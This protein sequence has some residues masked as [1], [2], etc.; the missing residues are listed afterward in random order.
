M[1]HLVAINLSAFVPANGDL[2]LD[3][4]KVSVALADFLASFYSK[5]Y[6]FLLNLADDFFRDLHLP[7]LSS[8][9]SATL[10]SDIT[11][12]EVAHSIKGI[13]VSKAPG[14]DG[15]TRLYYRKFSPLLLPHLTAYFNCMKQGSLPSPDSLRAHVSMIPKTTKETYEPQAFLPISLFLFPFRENPVLPH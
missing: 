11:E 10:N 3:P 5:P 4:N 13:C 6:A 8:A 14:P 2:T 9:A 1:P 7:P 15:I 12:L